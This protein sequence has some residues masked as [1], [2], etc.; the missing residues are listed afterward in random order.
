MSL[1]IESLKIRVRAH[2]L[3]EISK[4]EGVDY[5]KEPMKDQHGN[6]MKWINVIDTGDIYQLDEKELFPIDEN[7]YGTKNIPP[8]CCSL[9]IIGLQP[10]H[11]HEQ[12]SPEAQKRAIELT[13]YLDKVSFTSQSVRVVFKDLWFSTSTT[14][15][16]DLEKGIDQFECYWF[17]RQYNLC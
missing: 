17:N 7:I 16:P 5:Q 9:Q 2:V 3:A 1:L 13:E 15:K 10:P 14:L 11:E 12:Y 4:F 8:N 6:A